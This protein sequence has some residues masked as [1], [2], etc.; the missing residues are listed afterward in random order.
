MLHAKKHKEK[1]FHYKGKKYVAME[2]KT[3][4]TVYKKA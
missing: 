2:T 3:G 1:E 4:M